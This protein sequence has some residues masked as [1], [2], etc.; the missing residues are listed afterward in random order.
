VIKEG[1]Q[2]QIERL[3]AS[4]EAVYTDAE[5]ALGH[6]N[7]VGCTLSFEQIFVDSGKLGL[8]LTKQYQSCDKDCNPAIEA[9]LLAPLDAL[10]I[11]G[12]PVEVVVLLATP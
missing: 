2:V 6:V 9:V 5:Q 11:S 1:T 3:W 4:C 10:E 7:Q 8:W 12:Q